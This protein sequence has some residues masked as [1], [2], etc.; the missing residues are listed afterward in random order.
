MY[1]SALSGVF[2][3]I[4]HIIKRDETESLSAENQTVIF[5]GFFYAA[6]LQNSGLSKPLQFLGETLFKSAQR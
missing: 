1:R 3:K 4:K 6:N 5:A 2:Q